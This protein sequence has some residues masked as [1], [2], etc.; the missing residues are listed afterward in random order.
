MI[1]SYKKIVAAIVVL[2]GS[3]TIISFTRNTSSAP[4]EVLSNYFSQ[5]NLSL[6]KLDKI[7]N[8]FR[9]GKTSLDSVQLAVKN[10]RLSYKKV[11]FFLAF[12]YAE[13]IKSHING[14]PLMH[15]EKEGT[16]PKV[17]SPEGLQVLDELVFSDEAEAERNQI[18]SLSKTIRMKYAVLYS[19]ITGQEFNNQYNVTAMRQQLIRDF[20][21]GVTGFDTPGSLNGLEEVKSSFQ[22]MLTFF[23]D[24]YNGNTLAKNEVI[25]LFEEAIVY[26]NNP[27]SFEDFDRLTFLKSYVDP[28]YKKLGELEGAVNP[29]YLKY[30]SGWNPESTSIFAADFL[31]PYY[32][33]ELKKEDDSK[34]L[35]ELGKILFYDPIVS[36]EGKLS[37]ASCHN[38][39]KGFTDGVP[40]SLSNI[41]GK[42]VLR[43]APTLLNAVYADR[44]FYDLR[45]FSLEQQAEHV[46]FNHDEFNTAYSD[47][48]NKLKADKTYADKFKTVFGKNAV[49]RENFSKALVSYVM[50]LQS[51][52]SPFDK[53]IRGEQAD[54]PA[55]VKRG[56]N[57][58]AGKANC[59]TCHFMPTFSGLVPPFYNENESEILGVL[60]DPKKAPRLDM[61]MG[62]NDNKIQSE[63]AWI[64]ERSFK[65]TTIR[66]IEVTGPYFHNGAY[67]TL[68]E[69]IDFYDNGGGEGVGL[70]VSNQTLS[71]DALN[72]TDEEKSDLIAFLKS[73]TDLSSAK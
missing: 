50:S 18:A 62:R 43:N 29:D 51:F 9:Y 73:L 66:N 63:Q 52:S 46:I 70:G 47:I 37:C 57:L 5:F 69:V 58:F 20:S 35:R 21:M 12:Y 42:T 39:D 55:E 32:F 49:T 72:L 22:G 2:A 38:P 10:T 25:D 30:T 13:Y 19:S 16:M 17:V 6:E 11:E 1:G 54:I 27:V 8:D 36:N 31:N 67:S 33:T 59:A 34:E 4:P 7:T 53:Y 48:L 26:L 68:E 56:F 60:D 14:A 41:Q 44:Y 24:N 15:I 61:D 45:A 23:K 40:K 3:F 71:P 64:F 65:T 28:L